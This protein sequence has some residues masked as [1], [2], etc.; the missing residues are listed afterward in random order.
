[1]ISEQWLQAAGFRVSPRAGLLHSL[2]AVYAFCDRWEQERRGLPYATDGVVV[3]LDDLRLQEEA[4]FT[5]KAPRWAIALKY[6]AEEAPSRLLRLTCQ[7]CGSA[8]VREEGEAAIR[9]V[10]NDGGRRGGRRQAHQG[11]VP[12]GERAG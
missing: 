6:A 10:Y 8:L 1:M 3:K 9:C 11:P 5:Q 12:G 4:G 2:A 7:E